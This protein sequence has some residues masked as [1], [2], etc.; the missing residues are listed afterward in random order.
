M[1]KK[2]HLK[3][4]F[5]L[6]FCLVITVG[7][8]S[9]AFSQGP[10]AGK[11]T[12]SFEIL[13]EENHLP[14]AN[15]NVS[16]SGPVTRWLLSE[17]DGYAI[18]SN[19]P[20]GNYSVF[21]TAPNYSVKLSQSVTL[22]GNTTIILLF[23]TT[24]AFFDYTPSLVKAKTVVHFDASKS[25]SSGVIT[26]Y[27]WNFGDGATAK[28]NVTTTHAFA[29]SGV[30]RVS[31]TVTSTVGTATYTQ[32]LTVTKTNNNYIILLLLIPVP[33]IIFFFYSRRK[34]YVVIQARIPP[35]RKHPLCPG[36][37]TECEKCNLT[38]C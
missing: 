37:D 6:L 27:G 5:L 29:A 38:P 34:Y 2:P 7:L 17:P 33:F 22:T 13:Q 4:T 36:D 3:I 18:F 1:L 25:S 30:Y 20:L 9:T 31:L 11:C 19:I 16:I 14:L 8:P 23:S 35:T 26:G 32:T 12:L 10:A 28:T 21:A 24:T 15:A